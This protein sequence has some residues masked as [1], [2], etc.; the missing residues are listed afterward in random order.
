MDM[1]T[2]LTLFI[3]SLIMMSCQTGRIPCPTFKTARLTKS[4]PGQKT[5]ASAI[6]RVEPQD[7]ERNKEAKT[8][9]ISNTR[10]VRNVSVEEWDCPEPGNKKYLPRRVKEN[11]RRNFEKINQDD[12]R[13]SQD[14]LSRR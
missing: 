6:A 2:L 3:V 13:A 4:N 1:R 9:K 12:M 10:F 8:A 11:I 14:S 7:S 5:Y